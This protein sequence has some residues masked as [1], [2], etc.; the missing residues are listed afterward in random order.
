MTQEK[1]N[2]SAV[3]SMKGLTAEDVS[4]IANDCF[5]KRW[6]TD[7]CVPH[8]CDGSEVCGEIIRT[9]QR[10]RWIDGIVFET[11]NLIDDLKAL[12]WTEA[13]ENLVMIRRHVKRLEE[14]ISEGDH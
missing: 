9:Q 6:G 1:T 12:K 13:K 10:N 2:G 5:K 14:S 7:Q 3:L 11:H 4:Q 8:F